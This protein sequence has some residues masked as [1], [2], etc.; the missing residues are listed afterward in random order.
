MSPTETHG[1]WWRGT[2]TYDCLDPPGEDMA[3]II[4]TSRVSEDPSGSQRHSARGLSSPWCLGVSWLQ[5]APV[6][7]H[8]SPVPKPPG[9]GK[10]RCGMNWEIG[11]DTYTLLCIKQITNENLL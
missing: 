3:V 1:L 2:C 7:P 10:G 4:P 9:W 5:P 6:W 8:H 11:I